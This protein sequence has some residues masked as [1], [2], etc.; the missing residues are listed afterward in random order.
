MKVEVNILL[1]KKFEIPLE[2][3]KSVPLDEQFDI[4]DIEEEARKYIKIPEGWEEVD[5]FVD[6]E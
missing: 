6:Y 3:D 5:F 2:I 1:N 4:F